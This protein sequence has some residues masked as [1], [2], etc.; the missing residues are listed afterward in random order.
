MIPKGASRFLELQ[1]DFIP[2]ITEGI[3]ENFAGAVID[4]MPQPTRMFLVLD[5][6]PVSRVSWFQQRCEYAR[7]PCKAGDGLRLSMSDGTTILC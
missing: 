7:G 4:R 6:T 3:R 5:V 1:E 2:A